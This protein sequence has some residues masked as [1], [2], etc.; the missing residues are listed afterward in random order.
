MPGK[1]DFEA[2]YAGQALGTDDG[3]RQD[4]DANLQRDGGEEAGAAAAQ[5]NYWFRHKGHTRA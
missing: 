5:N 1:S 4:G 2:M 3:H